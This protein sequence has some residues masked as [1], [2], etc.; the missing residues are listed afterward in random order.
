VAAAHEQG[1]I[2]PSAIDPA[3]VGDV[4]SSGVYTIDIDTGGTFTDAY[5]TGKGAAVVAKADTTPHDPTQGVLQVIATA[6][7]TLRMSRTQLLRAAGVIRFST[8]VGTNTLINRDGPKVALLYDETLASLVDELPSDIPIARDMCLPIGDGSDAAAILLNVRGALDR[9]ARLLVICLASG[10]DLPS[11]ESRVRRI[12]LDDYPRHY[13]GALPLMMSHQITLLANDR[14][15]IQTALLDAYLHPVMV[16][17][18]YRVEDELRAG[19]YRHPLLVATASGGTSRVAKTTALRTWGSGPAGG[20]S[21]TAAMAKRLGVAHAIGI[22][23]GGTSTDVCL[24][25]EGEW[26]YIV[27]PTICGAAVSLPVLALESFAMGG[28]TIARV[29]KGALK[30]G[31]ESAGAQPGPAAFGLGGEDPTLTDAACAVGFFDPGHF[32]GGRKALQI[33]AAQSAIER[34]IAVP[35]GLTVQQASWLILRQASRYVADEIREFLKSRKLRPAEV[36]LF[37]T[38]GGGGLIA[39]SIATELGT[40]TVFAF[41]VSPVFSAFGLSRLGVLHTYDILPGE[42]VCQDINATRVRALADMRTEGV[43]LGDVVC[44]LEAEVDH[45]LGPEVIAIALDGNELKTPLPSNVRLLRFKAWAPAQTGDFPRWVHGTA[46]RSTGRLVSWPR[47][48]IKTPVIDWMSIKSGD[49]F[50]GPLILESG[51]T[52]VVISE[53]AKVT[54]GSMGEARLSVGTSQE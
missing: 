35:L 18:L 34:R 4:T 43:S 2:M 10:A 16:R 24:I 36:A 39:E 50:V 8:T 12:I 42:T 9:G 5:V 29:E 45:G 19:G 49:T 44:S 6:A 47:A 11:R 17:F 25:R 15:R 41:P 20:V 22:D 31:P 14:I 32:L 46:L 1:E 21:A 33:A 7:A 28:G 27:Q 3:A 40:P 26:E 51:E 30:L 52:T 48:T 37:A 54:I 38:G 53:R 23:V 13:L